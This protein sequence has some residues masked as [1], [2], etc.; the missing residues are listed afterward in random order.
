MYKAA[1]ICISIFI[2]VFVL[3]QCKTEFNQTDYKSVGKAL[4]SHLSKKDYS[5][6]KKINPSQFDTISENAQKELNKYD[7]FISNKP[8]FFLIDT[9]TFLGFLPML[10]L[11]YFY[12]DN[13]YQLAFWYSMD[14]LKKIYIHDLSFVNLNELCENGRKMLYCPDDK[15]VFT[16]FAWNTDFYKKSFTHGTITLQNNSDYD[17]DYLKFR[18]ILKNKNNALSSQ[19]FFNRTIEYNRNI[20]K[21]DLIR[22]EI[23]ELI[24]YSANFIITYDNLI[25][26]PSLIQVLPIPDNLSCYKLSKL[27][28]IYKNHKN[29]SG[30]R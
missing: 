4:H 5:I 25:I 2:L 23:N 15:V 19:V 6:L 12:N 22:I 16:N 30:E 11:N 26:E 8:D 29:A 13:F 14:S 10:E 24:G 3:A 18:L 9:S 17:I 28:E 7:R 27:K 1:L 20:P 21:G